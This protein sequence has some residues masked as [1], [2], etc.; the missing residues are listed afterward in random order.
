MECPTSAFKRKA[1]LTTLILSAVA[2]VPLLWGAGMVN[3]R[4]GG[5]SPFL[6][7]RLQQLDVALQ[8]G[9]FPPRWMPDMAYG[10]GYPFFN[11]Y[12]ALPY[13]VAVAF[14]RL[15][16]GYLGALKLT[17]AL[18]FLTAAWAMYSLLQRWH[19]NEVGAFLGALAYTYA[20][21]HLVNVYVR[22]DSLSEFYAFVFYPLILRSLADPRA[23]LSPRHAIPL[24]LSYAGLVLTHNVSA[25]IFSPFVALYLLAGLVAGRGARWHWA[26]YGG[27]GLLWGLALSVWFWWPALMERDLGHMADM[28]TGYF[29]FAGHF[30]GLNL[31]QWQLFFDY[32]ITSDQTPFAMGLFQAL[33]AVAGMGVLLWKAIRQRRLAGDAWFALGALALS[34]F[35]ITPL[36]R[37]LWEHVPLLPMVQF[38]WRFLSVQ[39]LAV[40]LV[41]P[42]LAEISPRW[43]AWIL[44]GLFILVAMG[45]LQPER[46]YIYK[47]D[48]TPERLR[49][50]ELFTGNIGSTVRY[51]YLPRWVEPRPYTSEAAI[52][53]AP[54]APP[55][56]LAGTLSQAQLL[57]LRP[58]AEEWQVTTGPEGATLAFQTYYFPGWRG[59]VDGQR[60][61]ITPLEGLGYIRLILPGGE[62]RVA[63]R[64]QR[65]P[66]RAACEAFS[67]LA[68]LGAGIVLVK[69]GL[70]IRRPRTLRLVMGIAL[71]LCVVVLI[72]RL[73]D[74]AR[75]GTKTA[76]APSS[77][78]TMDFARQPYLHHNPQGLDFGG[79]ARLR[80]YRLERERVRAG[81][82]L[83]LTLAW[84]TPG[85]TDLVAGVALASLAEPLFQA[86]PPLAEH[87]A[88]VEA[89]ESA[90]AL[91]VP[92]RIVPGL[93]LL[94]VR[95]WEG[96]RELVPRTPR[97]EALG[98]TYLQPVPVESDLQASPP[99]QVLGEFGPCLT[100]AEAAATQ[101]ADGLHVELGW[102]VRCRVAQNYALSVRLKDSD[103]RTLQAV[104]I[105]PEHGFYPT[106]LWKAGESVP[107]CCFLPVP[108]GTPPGLEY[109]LEVVLYDVRTLQPVGASAVSGI[110]LTQPTLKADFPSLQRFAAELDLVDVQ[111]GAVEEGQPVRVTATWAAAAPPSR[112]YR[113]RLTLRNGDKTHVAEGPLVANYP[114]HLWPAQAYVR[115]EYRLADVLPG[116]YTLSLAVL[117]GESDASYGTYAWPGTVKVKARPHTFEI[118][119]VQMRLE[120][121]F[122]QRI[123]LLGYDLTQ[124]QDA[125][126][127]T[128]YWQA[129]RTMETDYKVFVHLFDP[130]L[131]KIVSQWDSMPREGTYPTTLWAAGEVVSDEATLSLKDVPGGSYRLAVGLYDPRNGERLSVSAD[132]GATISDDRIILTDLHR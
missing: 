69:G 23:S 35:L 57:S 106:S 113:L 93:Y 109:A 94:S 128:L 14:K 21:F 101:K 116:A 125:L 43:L 56:A 98:T 42:H 9:A 78:L 72:S 29:H 108:E 8:G 126:H 90:H 100:L 76:P 7:V 15:G 127:L 74:A 41:V 89:G 131:E 80:S 44:G 25:L 31:V 49:L 47:G 77:D 61:E 18:G 104:D 27:I 38:P 68:A 84:D 99:T 64:F 102:W 51:E 39:A 85:A 67:L 103:G 117:D 132:S 119:A 24:A 96:E 111:V 73:W 79:K 6:L 60:V 12:A 48:I 1:I 46:L 130:A 87:R 91:A 17:Q 2:C 26:L 70:T 30:R 86:R 120:A 66:S 88:R 122:G 110:A 53:G 92:A 13:Y 54:K 16:L 36:S 95:L 63:L 97:G 20:P 45:K 114:T 59:Y 4:A 71:V 105:Q 115:A 3:T 65:T 121:N 22:G 33:A 107:T 52:A 28:T 32:S 10:Y 83:R 50:Y 118:P 82:T 58:N 11:H 112:D 40:A 123:Q 129:L 55:L 75:P 34:T 124:A 19:A 62:H 37:P 5:D 81:E